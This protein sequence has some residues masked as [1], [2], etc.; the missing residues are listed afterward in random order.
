MAETK[1]LIVAASG[2]PVSI[3]I[4]GIGSEEFKL[5]QELDSDNQIL[6]DSK[7]NPALR[8]IVQFVKF[9]DLRYK[10]ISAIAEEVLKEI[11]EQVVEFLVM[12][13]IHIS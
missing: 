13:N 2:M 10:G 8:D 7:G 11:P 9:N 4:I 6:K 1:K 12:N 5:M 3:I